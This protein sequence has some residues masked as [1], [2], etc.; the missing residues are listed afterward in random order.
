MALPKK[1]VTVTKQLAYNQ[2]NIPEN[3]FEIFLGEINH[4]LHSLNNVTPNDSKG[5]LILRALYL[6]YRRDCSIKSLLE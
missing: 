1:Q 2:K 4:V 3:N 6:D 5:L